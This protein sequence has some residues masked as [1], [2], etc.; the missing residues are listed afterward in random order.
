MCCT[1]SAFCAARQYADIQTCR[2]LD[3]ESQGQPANALADAVTGKQ[4][5]KDIERT[6]KGVMRVGLLAKGLL[7]K[8]DNEVQLVVLCSKKPS[9]TLLKRI[10]SFI[11]DEL[12][13]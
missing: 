7:L 4:E 8:G 1:K 3:A 13:V 10:A 2:A 5:K 12:T 11:P 6:L 9:K